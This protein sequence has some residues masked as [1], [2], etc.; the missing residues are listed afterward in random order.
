M[1]AIKFRLKS[2]IFHDLGAWVINK[3]KIFLSGLLSSHTCPA[4]GTRWHV[5]INREGPRSVGQGCHLGRYRWLTDWQNPGT[6]VYWCIAW[7]INWTG[8]NGL[9]RFVNWKSFLVICDMIKNIEINNV[10]FV[11]RG[12]S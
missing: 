12:F 5:V 11:C 6:D 3:Y 10:Y 8:P 4:V 7:V 9:S 1:W 2:K